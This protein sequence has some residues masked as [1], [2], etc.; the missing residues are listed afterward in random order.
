MLYLDAIRIKASPLRRR[1]PNY[2][3]PLDFPLLRPGRKDRNGHL[4]CISQEIFIAF[5]LGL[6]DTPSPA[7][8]HS[9][10][11]DRALVAFDLVRYRRVTFWRCHTLGLAGLGIGYNIG[12]TRDRLDCG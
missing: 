2:A 12:Y 11:L 10:T 8:L 7:Q 6:L 1:Y 9:R 4:T 3:G 5:A